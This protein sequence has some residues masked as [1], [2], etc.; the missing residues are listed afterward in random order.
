MRIDPINM[1]PANCRRTAVTMLEVISAIAVLGTLIV[2]S[3]EL[4]TLARAQRRGVVQ[5]SVALIEAQNA[6]ERLT[7]TT[8]DSIQ[9]DAQLGQ[10]SLEPHAEQLLPDGQITASAVESADSAAPGYRLSVEVT[11]QLASGQTAAPVRLTT[12]VFPSPASATT[13][14]D[15]E[16]EP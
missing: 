5:R 9:L 16:V 15:P 1:K 13:D 12:W 10:L 8:H 2:V 11:W 6:L 3:A 4:L 14:T 7:A